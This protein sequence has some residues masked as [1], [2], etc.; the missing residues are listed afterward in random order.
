[1]RNQRRRRALPS[2]AMSIFVS[3]STGDSKAMAESVATRALLSGRCGKQSVKDFAFGEKSAPPKGIINH[4]PATLPHLGYCGFVM[5]W[6]RLFLLLVLV[7]LAGCAVNGAATYPIDTAG[8]YQLNTGDVVRVTV[9][10]DKDLSTSYKIDDAG[11]IS[12]P[13]VGPVH[14]AG[15]TTAEA[16]RR[17]SA[18]L[19]H[20]YMRNPNVVVEVADYRPFFI[21]GEV[22]N[23]GQ[24]PYVYGMT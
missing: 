2:A 21:Q 15:A 22:N 12:F 14:V 9:Y 1:M 6:L 24:F 20:G 3:V 16:A 17:L 7:P 18:A 23:S 4:A 13:L 19:A 11:A 8:P 5:R 10:G